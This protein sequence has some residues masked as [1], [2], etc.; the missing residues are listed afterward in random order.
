[1]QSQQQGYVF[2]RLC[3]QGSTDLV[4]QMLD[5]GMDVDLAQ[6]DGCT[7]LWLAAEAGAV[8]VVRLLCTRRASTNVFKNPGNVSA[9]FIASQNGHSS[10]VDVLLLNGANPNTPK[11]TGATPLFIAAQ[12]NF[13]DVVRSLLRAG[14]NYSAMNTSGIG[15]LHIACY[16]GNTAVVQLLLAAGADPFVACQG[17]TAVEWAAANGFRNEVQKCIDQHL[18]TLETEL[19]RRRVEAFSAS[20]AISEAPVER[21]QST[22]KGSEPASTYVVALPDTASW[23]TP[24]FLV[25]A[26][27]ISQPKPIEHEQPKRV[28]PPDHRGLSSDFLAEEVKRAEHFRKIIRKDTNALAPVQNVG[29]NKSGLLAVE[30]E[31]E[32]HKVRLD[33]ASEVLEETH[34]EIQDAW[35]Y[36]TSATARYTAQMLENRKGVSETK[37]VESRDRGGKGGFSYPHLPPDAVS[38]LRQFMVRGRGAA[39]PP[40]PLPPEE[41]VEETPAPRSVP[42]VMPSEPMSP[43]VAT[44]ASPTA[45]KSSALARLKSRR[46]TT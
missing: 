43:S 13:P 20:E 16:Q 29:N 28:F 24:N 12:Q 38:S 25:K 31:W 2:R 44:P 4:R 7:G 19:H 32:A 45:S 9:L 5:A 35:M 26:E 39:G 8:E 17:K 40:P 1:M 33:A 41:P 6:D 23:Y 30:Q 36:A 42:T 37:V 21:K 11:S 10:V 18:R 27:V 34:Q 3:Q 15:P 22:T 14:A 46:G